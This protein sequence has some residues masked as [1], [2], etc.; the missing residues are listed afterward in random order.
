MGAAYDNVC[1]VLGL[2]VAYWEWVRF[3]GN[4]CGLRRKNMAYW[5]MC[6]LLGMLV[7]YWK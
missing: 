1:G 6:G 3:L 5:Q 7:A 2:C 4:G